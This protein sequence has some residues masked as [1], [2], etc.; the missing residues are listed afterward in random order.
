MFAN[1][2]IK[3]SWATVES[4]GYGYRQT[5]TIESVL[6]APVLAN[7]FYFCHSVIWAVLVVQF[8]LIFLIVRNFCST[9]FRLA[10][11]SCR[12]RKAVGKVFFAKWKSRLPSAS[13][14]HSSFPFASLALH[15]LRII[16]HSKAHNDGFQIGKKAFD[17]FC[18]NHSSGANWRLPE[19]K[20]DKKTL[21]VFWQQ[22]L[23]LGHR[24]RLFRFSKKFA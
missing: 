9:F 15:F 2:G 20:F 18:Q 7:R 22:V 17:I 3:S 14:F 21:R 8:K 4:G 13:L 1:N 11:N 24:V 12:K 19:Q 10:N 16:L 5:Q 6:A 23:L